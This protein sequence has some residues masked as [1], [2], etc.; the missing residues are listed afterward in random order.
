MIGKLTAMRARA[1]VELELMLG[2][3]QLRTLERGIALAAGLRPGT[4][5]DG[6]VYVARPG[7]RGLPLVGI[8]GFGGDKETWLMC[9]ALVGRARGLALVDLPSHGRS[10]DV[11]ES[12]A[13]IRHH[14]EA[15]LRVMDR[16]Q[17]DRAILCGNSMGGGVALRIARTNPERVAGLVLVASVGDSLHDEAALEWLEGENPLIPRESDIERFM[18]F[19]LERPPPLVPRAVVRYAITR[20]ARRAGKLQRLFRGLVL[21]SGADGVPHDLERIDQPT[22]VVH[23][24]HDRVIPRPVA[25]DLV[26]RLPRAELVVMR[27]VGH[28]PQLEAP[29]P[30]ARAIERF[31]RRV[32]AAPPAP[33][34]RPRVRGGDK[35]VDARRDPE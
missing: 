34:I 31:A 19:V 27:H 1:R 30:M 10:P 3:L 11:D 8:H 33:Q 28:T 18:Q 32:E 24:E 5:D 16:A 25:D 29:R 6:I 20:R 15:V 2:G 23:G 7:R 17:I 22:L 26:A 4:T 14:A 9:A 35:P 21:G 13:T 12:R